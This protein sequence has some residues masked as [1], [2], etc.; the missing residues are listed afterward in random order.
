MT[1]ISFDHFSEPTCRQWFG[2]WRSV[3]RLIRKLPSEREHAPVQAITR[4]C[5]FRHSHYRRPRS[6]LLRNMT[7]RFK[8]VASMLAVI[9]LAS[10]ATALGSCW[11][12]MAGAKKGTPHCAMMNAQAKSATVRSAPSSTACC[13]VSAT[14]P[15]PAVMPQAPSD[16]GARVVSILSTSALDAPTTV[17]KSE[18]P[19]P[20]A[21]ASGLSLQAVFCTFLI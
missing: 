13:Q 4:G 12:H 20:L 21:R 15:T 10:H 5:D 7:W 2:S 18:P 3:E 8:I 19:D 6:I 9:L 14:K 16:S 1:V 11:L 17:T